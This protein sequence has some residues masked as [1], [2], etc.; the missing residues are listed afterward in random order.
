MK[1]LTA[2]IVSP[3][4]YGL[5][6]STSVIMMHVGLLSFLYPIYNKLMLASCDIEDWAGVEVMWNVP[7]V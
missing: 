6:H 3:I 2:Y 4:L 7:Q 1:K 5:G